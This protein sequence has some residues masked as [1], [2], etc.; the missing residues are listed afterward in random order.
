MNRGMPAP[1]NERVRRRDLAFPLL[2]VMIL[3]AT[4]ACAPSR[5]ARHLE[6][7]FP[8]E[9]DDAA[10]APPPAPASPADAPPDAE[11]DSAAWAEALARDGAR[12]V[13]SRQ[14]RHLWLMDGDSAV[15]SAPVAIGRD[16]IFTYDGRDYDFSTPTGRRT[17]L[18][19]EES[20]DWVPPNWHYYEKAVEDGLEPVHLGRNQRV[21]LSDSTVIE[22]RSGEVGRINRFGNW[23][24]FTPG[25]EIIFDGKI[26]IPPIPSPQRQIPRILGT[27]RL[28]LGDGYLIHGTPEV[29]SIGEEASHGCIRMFNRDVQ[30]LYQVVERGTPVYVY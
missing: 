3:L 8:G 2:T 25:A 23:Y 22:V 12:I 13:V 10:P 14:L 16:T 11:G 18:G 26:F 4:S 6:W 29:D 30:V 17:V 1:R 9:A 20:P 19:K 5:D 24:P 27:H 21:T 15:F 7:P 28:I